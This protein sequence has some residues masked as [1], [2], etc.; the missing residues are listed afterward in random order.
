MLISTQVFAETKVRGDHIRE[1]AAQACQSILNQALFY[2]AKKMISCDA[3]IND[4]RS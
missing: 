1:I 2:R 4:L 3:E